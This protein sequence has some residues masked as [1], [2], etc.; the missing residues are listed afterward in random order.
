MGVSFGEDGGQMRLT[1]V[2]T[3]IKSALGLV[4]RQKSVNLCA[5]GVKMCVSFGAQ[6]DQM[7]VNFGAKGDQMH[8]NFVTQGEQK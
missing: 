4:H 2:H 8:V 6:E 3:Q 5:Q 1:W 7:H